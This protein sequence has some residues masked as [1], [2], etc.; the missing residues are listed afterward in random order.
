MPFSDPM[1]D[2]PADPGVVAAGPEGRPDDAQ[3]PRLWCALSAP[4][5]RTTPV[6]LMGYYNPI[7]IYRRREISRRCRGG[8]RRWPDHRRSAARGTTTN[9]ACRR[10]ERGLNF[11]RLATP[12]TDDQAP[13]DGPHQHLGLR[14]LCIGARHHRHRRRRTSSR[15]TS[16]VARI[17]QQTKLPVAVGFRREDGRARRAPSPRRRRRGGRLGPRQRDARQRW[18]R[19]RTDWKTVPSVLDLVK[20]LAQALRTPRRERR[21]HPSASVARESR[22]C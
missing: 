6:M 12:T 22:M 11:I 20:S 1:A 9:C 8:R 18:A 2:G 10:I 7:Y 5:T 13:A 21:S 14:L 16:N 17:K 3:D 19:R 15:F 4:A